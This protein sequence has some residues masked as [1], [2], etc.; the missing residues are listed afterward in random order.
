MSIFVQEVLGLLNRNQKKTTLDLSKDYFEFGKLYQTSSLNNKSGYTPKMEP[1]LIKWGDIIDN[2]SCQVTKDMTRTF[3]GQGVAGV[4]PVYTDP[5]GVCSWDTLKS[6]IITQNSLNTIIN[7]NGIL[8]VVGATFLNGNVSLGNNISDVIR[9]Y[10]TLYD[11][12][13]NPPL[14]N[15]V[16]VGQGGGQAFWQNDDVTEALTYGSIWR[17][18]S[19]DVKEQ[20]AIGA[21]NT[22]L[23]SNGTT[24]NWTAAPWITAFAVAGNTGSAFDI[25]QSNTLS[26]LGGTALSSI[27]SSPD[28]VT[29][30][31]LNYGTAG[32]YAYP[33][34]IT[35]NEQGHIT[36]ITSGSVSMSSFNAA[37]D[38]GTSQIISNGDTLTITG[39]VALT[40]VASA[41]DTIT[42]N[43]DN[44]AVTPASYTNAN[45]TVDQQG[46]I[47]SASN[48]SGASTTFTV[49]GD[50]GSSQTI[51]NG[52]T[53]TISGGVGLS[54]VASATDIITVNLDNTAVTPGTYINSTVTVDQQ[55]RI[56]N[57]V[58]GSS[59]QVYVALITQ[60]L[61][62]PTSAPTA[63]VIKDSFA[64]TVVFTY[65]YVSIGRYRLTASSP[66]FTVNNTAPYF[67]PHA[68]LG[69]AE[70]Q[71]KNY[72]VGINRINDTIIEFTSWKAGDG[73]NS[74]ER[75]INATLKIEIY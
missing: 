3:P 45:I 48:G 18:N 21:V 14:I 51:S 6:S 33:S 69:D 55:G 44:T 54:S 70:F 13:G 66:I 61:S 40:S 35:T 11:N 37:G 38:S 1:F 10:G 41:T 27:T 29:I 50:T 32:T 12:A 23:I 65:S 67:I 58:A 31:H 19:S 68:A 34:S 25:T 52:D 15:Q 62:V 17:G 47:T 74:D 42:L 49:A 28:T 56:T 36:A 2:I 22:V 57:I 71:G 43:L 9:L 24:L 63:F 16:L 53:L 73:T 59:P 4:I 5:S 7:I 20:L 75:I 46:R 72:G 26:I 30:N 8:E 60:G 39:G 64:G